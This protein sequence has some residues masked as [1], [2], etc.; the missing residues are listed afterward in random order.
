VAKLKEIPVKKFHAV[1][2]ILILASTLITSPVQAQTPNAVVYAVLF[3]SPDCGH[4]HY[5]INETLPPLFAKYGD[6]L[7]IIGVD[8]TQPDGQ[9]LFL[10]ALQ[11]F[12]LEQGGVPFL[13]V[14][15]VYLIGSGEIPEQ[16]PLLIETY[17]AQGGM[18]WPDIPGLRE[19]LGLSPAVTQTS[20]PLTALPDQPTPQTDPGPAA[21]AQSVIPPSNLPNLTLTDDAT[22][23]EK[24]ARD[25]AGNSLSVLVLLFMF[26]AAIWSVIEFRKQRKIKAPI[27][28][29]WDI[30]V[31]CLMGFGVAGYLAYVESA[32]VTAVCGPVGDCNT[33]QQS[34]Y[35]R[36]FGILPIGVLGLIGYITIALA[37]LTARYTKG[38]ISNWS[39]LALFVFSAFGT[40]FSIYLTFLEP[41]V[42][43]ATC[44]W[45]LTSAVLITIIMLLSLRPAKM[46][47]GRLGR[48]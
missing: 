6:Q 14:G 25:P 41:F 11:K 17:L 42:I 2:V 12:G 27:K 43:G 24:F 48:K 16:F 19:T 46:A 33:V 47:M 28:W 10:A 9:A 39:A 21:T 31:L 8:V 22:W 13:V 32:H 20:P 44:A 34:A 29:S 45:C 40:L 35:A 38:Q 30:P 5:V 26:A 23:Q 1:L 18:D 15:D 36:L 37:W 4:C 7:Q 3:Y